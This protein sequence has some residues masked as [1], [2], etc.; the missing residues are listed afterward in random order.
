[1]E[2]I[3]ITA[4][5]KPN[6]GYEEQLLQE[7]R[8]VQQASRAEAGCLKYDLHRATDEQTYILLEAWADED[9]FERHLQT[10]HY[11]NYREAAAGMIAS[12]NLYKMKEI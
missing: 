9:A 1:M 3:L 10:P 7:M 12:R 5:L 6:P 11:L 4:V 2:P 8:K